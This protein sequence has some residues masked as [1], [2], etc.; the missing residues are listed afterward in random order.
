MKPKIPDLAKAGLPSSGAK[1][2]MWKRS[3]RRDQIYVSCAQRLALNWWNARICTNTKI[4]LHKYFQLH[5]AL[6]HYNGLLLFVHSKYTAEQSPAVLTD[7]YNL[8]STMK[9]K[10]DWHL[11]Q[12]WQTAGIALIA[13][14]TEMKLKCYCNYYGTTVAQWC[15]IDLTGNWNETGTKLGCSGHL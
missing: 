6:H 5:W 14:K 4:Q 7:N 2:G 1:W 8:C 3:S 10:K 11:H 13:M 15:Y 12:K 9:V